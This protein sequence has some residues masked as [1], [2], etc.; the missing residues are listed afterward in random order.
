[1]PD[2]LDALG[3]AGDADERFEALGELMFALV[4][5]ARELKVDP[6][7]ALRAAADRFRERTSSATT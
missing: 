6:E 2:R 4:A 5:V 7:L 3:R 1:L